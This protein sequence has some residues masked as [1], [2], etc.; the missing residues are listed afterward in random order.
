MKNMKL[1]NR[2]NR[3]LYIKTI[4]KQFEKYAITETIDPINT[5]DFAEKNFIAFKCLSS[6]EFF[7]ERASDMS[8][9]VEGMDIGTLLSEIDEL[10]SDSKSKRTIM[11]PHLEM[12][13][14]EVIDELELD[15]RYEFNSD[16]LRCYFDIYDFNDVSEEFR[17]VLLVSF[18]DKGIQK[19][20]SISD[21]IITSNAVNSAVSLS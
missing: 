18:D 17:F 15:L 7:E 10:L 6:K 5:E 14:K 3:D 9:I 16:S 13:I 2:K 20:E 1:D 19:L 11:L 8:I 12:M 21:F 4:K